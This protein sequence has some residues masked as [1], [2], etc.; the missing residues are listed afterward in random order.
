[1]TVGNE[2]PVEEPADARGM[3]VAVLMI[4]AVTA[5]MSVCVVVAVSALMSVC[6]V[7]AVTVLVPVGFV[8]MFRMIVALGR[9]SCRRSFVVMIVHCCS[10]VV[11]V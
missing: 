3:A 11:S 9:S 1:M 10:P 2:K 5:L 6:V 4:V 8:I 7:V